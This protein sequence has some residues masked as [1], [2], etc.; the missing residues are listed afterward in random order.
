MVLS[1]V[2][3]PLGH[4]AEIGDFGIESVQ[5][6]VSRCPSTELLLYLNDCFLGV[7][8][9]VSQGNWEDFAG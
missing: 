7:T 5:I 1:I 9:G 3:E 4:S 6:G 2:V 8:C